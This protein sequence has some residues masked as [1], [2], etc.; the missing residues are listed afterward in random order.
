MNFINFMNFKNILVFSLL[1]L[2]VIF[3]FY[4]RFYG[5]K[6]NHSFWADEAYISSLARDL[7]LSKKS[8]SE[9]LQL[10]NYQT[11]N[12]IIVYISFVILGISEFSARFPYIFF[13]TVGIVFS[14]LLAEKLANRAAGILAAFLHA[15]SQI[16]LANSTQSKP[17]TLIQTLFLIEL[18]LITL[19]RSKKDNKKIHLGIIIAASMSTFA[20]IIGIFCWI[21]YLFFIVKEYPNLISNIFKKKSYIFMSVG[22]LMIVGIMFQFHYI[23]VNT[24]SL[25]VFRLKNFF[26]NNNL[27]FLREVLWKNNGFIFLPAIFG[28]LL[29]RRNAKNLTNGIL[30]YALF[31][32][33]FWTFLYTAHNLR[34]I[35]Q[36]FG[37]IFVYFGVF[38]GIVGSKL[39]NGKELSICL[40]IILLMYIGGNKI[41]RKPQLYYSPN[42]DLYGDV[43]I[44]DYKTVFAIL[45]Q[46]FPN[47]QTIAVFNNFIDAHRW[48]LPE[49][50]PDACFM[51]V[52]KP[53]IH[54]ADNVPY[55][56]K[57]EEFLKEKN[58]Y[59]EGVMIV[60]DWESLLPEDI[61]QYVKKN[62]KLEFR[63]D[64]LFQAADDKWPIEVYS[65]KKL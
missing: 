18:Y 64:G 52:D 8:F 33:F 60:E 20:H 22:V 26:T 42:Q 9:V 50:N 25:T 58:K 40:F 11:L 54:P 34:Y 48:Y 35:L 38:W 53:F 13:G 59:P 4:F 36:F 63:V 28:S 32:L 24:I 43:Q 30:I 31:L 57:L 6:G 3:G 16:N 41:V 45:K 49:K 10:I 44:A 29:M 14:F 39:F 23:I 55:Y 21:P 27:T 15:F 2:F 5:I 47:Y 56:S 19:I 37:L 61:K 12:I 51:K 46:K 17:Y 7:V 65:W 1:F 62:L